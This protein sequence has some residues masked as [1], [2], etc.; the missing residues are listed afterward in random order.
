MKN[1]LLNIKNGVVIDTP[2][3]EFTGYDAYVDIDSGIEP[4]QILIGVGI[5]IVVTLLAFGLFWFFKGTKK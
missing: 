2:T 4:V 5:G 1:W 3:S